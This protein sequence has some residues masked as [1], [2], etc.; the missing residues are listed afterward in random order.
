MEKS[1]KIFVQKVTGK[2]LYYV[3]EVDSM[4]LVALS[5]ITLEQAN[6]TKTKIKN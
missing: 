2:F 4:I 3:M 1:N 5:S 6:P